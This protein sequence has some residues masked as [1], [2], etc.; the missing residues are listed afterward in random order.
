MEVVTVVGDPGIVLADI[1]VLKAKGVLD[2]G[3]GIRWLKLVGIRAL[4]W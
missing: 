1:A 3:A 2:A 4:E